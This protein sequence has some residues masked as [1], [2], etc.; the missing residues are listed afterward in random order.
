MTFNELTEKVKMLAASKE[1]LSS[2]IK[3]KTDEGSIFLSP[4]GLVSN[5]DED[6]DCTISVD[7]D[8]LDKLMKGELNPMTA[9][10]FGKI[11]ISGDMSVAMQLKNLF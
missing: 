2:S 1:P 8:D 4:T 10:M 6:A 7:M 5:S 9:V 3:F 11:K